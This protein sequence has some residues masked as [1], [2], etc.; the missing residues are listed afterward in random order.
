VSATDEDRAPIRAE[1]MFGASSQIG[2][3]CE[4]RMTNE[5]R[6]EL[7]IRHS[8]LEIDYSDLVRCL[9]IVFDGSS[10]SPSSGTSMLSSPDETSSAVS[11]P[12]PDT[13][14]SVLN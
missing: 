7:E 12:D 11:S 5:E 6:G 4:F 13:P 2:S 10:R 14:I 8:P 9:P 1:A 3:N